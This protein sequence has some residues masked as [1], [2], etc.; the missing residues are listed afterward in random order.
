MN[1]LKMIKRGIKKFMENKVRTC[2]DIL[3]SAQNRLTIGFIMAGMGVGL[4]ASVYV[5]PPKD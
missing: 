3:S 5:H 1:K 2:A 4:I